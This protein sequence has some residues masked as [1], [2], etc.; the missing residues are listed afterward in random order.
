[1]HSDM[2]EAP[3]DP[4]GEVC[5][6]V[7]SDNLLWIYALYVANGGP[8]LKIYA[9]RKDSHCAQHLNDHIPHQKTPS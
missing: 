6:G 2:L 9:Q 3:K 1:M 4:R 7:C 8:K 5:R